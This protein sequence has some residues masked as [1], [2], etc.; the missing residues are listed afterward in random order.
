MYTNGFTIDDGPL[1]TFDDPAS[2]QFLETITRGSFFTYE[3]M[4]IFIIR[5]GPFSPT[6][7]QGS[8]CK[9]LR[10]YACVVGLLTFV[11]RTIPLELRQLH[12]AAKIELRMER[13][14]TEYVPPKA[15]PFE[16]NL[17]FSGFA[18]T[19][20]SEILKLP[21]CPNTTSF[22]FTNSFN[23]REKRGETL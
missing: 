22:Y 17:S 13:K 5:L 3:I 10:T 9:F 12:P 21:S 16:V 1:R 8:Y 11:C 23:N 18:H 15:K 20:V 6:D 19:R 4:N 14:M 7:C 2:R